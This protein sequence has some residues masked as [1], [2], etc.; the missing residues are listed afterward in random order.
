MTMRHG[1]PPIQKTLDMGM[2]PSLSGDVECTLV[3]P[4][5]N[6]P[7]AVVSLMERNNVDT[8]MVDGQI[9]KWAGQL[10]GIDIPKLTHAITASRNAIFARAG[11]DPDL[12]G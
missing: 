3:A 4:L 6:G 11:I 10:V 12:F 9:K 1:T 5:N 8:V 2:L 7:G